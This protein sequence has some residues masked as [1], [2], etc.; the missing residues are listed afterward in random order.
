MIAGLSKA[1][2][3]YLAPVLA[4]TATLLSLFAFLAPTLMLQDRVSL[5]VVSPSTAL[6]KPG[7]SGAVDGPTVFLGVLGELKKPSALLL[8][9]LI[10]PLQAR[11]LKP[12]MRVP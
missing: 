3:L 5:L 10:F 4:L 11:V 9:Y 6:S 12:R 2:T 1:I 7:S 8:F